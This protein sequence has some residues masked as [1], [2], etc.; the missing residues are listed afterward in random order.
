M[1][2]VKVRLMGV[3]GMPIIGLA[4]GSQLQAADRFGTPLSI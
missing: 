3:E 2:I 1:L 4:I